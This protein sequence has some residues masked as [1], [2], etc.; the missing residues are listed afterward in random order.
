MNPVLRNV[1]AFIAGVVV[2][3][4]VNGGL[5]MISGSVIPPP[6]GADV[7]TTEGLQASIHLFEP[8]HFIFPFLAHAVGT[9]VGALVAGKLAGN[10]KMK[11]ALGIG[12]L[13]LVGGISSTFMIP[14]PTWFIVVDLVFAY[15]PM[16]YIAGK[17]VA[18]KRTPVYS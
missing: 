10:S 14:A 15:I 9:F 7:T 18:G 16:A 3:S 4:I 5:I 11:I 2:G 6:A 17:L 8:K 1:L 12:F 13:F